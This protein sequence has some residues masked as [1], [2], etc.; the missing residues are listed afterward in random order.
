MAHGMT[1]PHYSCRPI[2]LRGGIGI[3]S[4][5]PVARPQGHNVPGPR[6]AVVIFRPR[7]QRAERRSERAPLVRA[8]M[9]VVVRPPTEPRWS[10]RALA[11]RPLLRSSSASF[12]PHGFAARF[13][14]YGPA[15][16]VPHPALLRRGRDL[17][18]AEPR[19]H[20]SANEFSED[21]KARVA[22]RFILQLGAMGNIQTRT[23]KA[24]P[25]AAYREIINSLG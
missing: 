7:R 18:A 6:H 24:F 15:L 17:D 19:P 8:Q 3:G 14:K 2:D 20:P 5:R 9:V 11:P 1:G 23:M 13:L 22:A 10:R 25:E 16:Q 4:L 21:P 12:T